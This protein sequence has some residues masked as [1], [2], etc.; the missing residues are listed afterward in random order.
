MKHIHDKHILMEIERRMNFSH[1]LEETISED[2]HRVE[3]I[4]RRLKEQ[5]KTD[6]YNSIIHNFH[7]EKVKIQNFDEFYRL[8][9]WTVIFTRYFKS[10]QKV[11][12][13]I[14]I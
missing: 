11:E 2:E 6:Y 13:T 8:N 1:D 4:M 9:W 3:F 5:V 7:D 14:Y 10:Y 12:Y